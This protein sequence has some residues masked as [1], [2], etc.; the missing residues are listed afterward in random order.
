M[1]G[2]VSDARYALREVV[3]LLEDV[4]SHIIDAHTF[5]GEGER[6]RVALQALAELKAGMRE[7]GRALAL[8]EAELGETEQEARPQ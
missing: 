6:A 7:A 2:R 5:E 8:L 1:S 3:V 4:P